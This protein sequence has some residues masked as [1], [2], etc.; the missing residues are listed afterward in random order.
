VLARKSLGVAALVVAMSAPG[1]SARALPVLFNDHY[2]EV[3]ATPFLPW[4]VADAAARASAFH[5]VSG[6]LATIT[7]FAED[8]FLR[9]LRLVTPGIN[10]SGAF[11]QS[12]V[13]VGGFQA[14]GSVE[15]GG[16][17][18]WVNSEGAIPTP[19]HPGPGYSNWAPFEPNDGSG[20]GAESHMTIGLVNQFGW[21]DEA[22]IAGNGDY[23]VEYDVPESGTLGLVGLGLAALTRRRR[24]AP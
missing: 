14:P 19:S 13:W 7:S 3:V 17:W 5:G 9:A 4:E 16:G 22:I 1:L 20:F 18:Q 15:P 2:Y 11:V 10:V 24:R 8:D 23:A 21:N 12:E 6:H